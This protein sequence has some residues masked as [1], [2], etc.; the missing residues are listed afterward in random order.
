MTLDAQLRDVLT[1]QA[2][3]REG[4]VPDLAALRAG[5]LTLR[6]RRSRLVMAS[7][8]LAVLLCRRRRGRTRRRPAGHRCDR[9]PGRPAS[10]RERNGQR[11]PGASPPRMQELEQLIEGEGAPI[12]T[13]C[14]TFRVAELW[15]HAGT[16]VLTRN[17]TTY[18][19][20]DGQAHTDGKRTGDVRMSHD[21]R[22]A[23]WMDLS[24]GRTNCGVLPLEVYEVATATEVATTRGARRTPAATLPASTTGAGST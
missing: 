19:V 1:E 17:G 14:R 18:R 13:L 10:R 8:A 3:R 23:A 20:A 7:S 2:D 22:L 6:R 11:C 9:P 12:R 5:G 16:T 21:G 4:P 15:H 24:N